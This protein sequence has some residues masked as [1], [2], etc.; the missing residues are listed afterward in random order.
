M[1]RGMGIA[2]PEW[3]AFL[4]ADDL[5]KGV[6]FY[7]DLLGLPVENETP[8]WVDFP[9]FSLTLGTEAFLEF[10]VDDFEEAARRLEARGVAVTR[11]SPHGGK[12]EDPFGNVIGL[13]DHRAEG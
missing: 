1:P 11:E 7:G 2:K 3:R 5:E 10:H 4:R 13:H 9:G 8:G 12:V 6:A